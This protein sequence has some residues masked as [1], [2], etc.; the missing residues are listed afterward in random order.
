MQPMG[1]NGGKDLS[2]LMANINMNQGGAGGTPAEHEIY[3]WIS[4]LLNPES[5]EKALLEL[6]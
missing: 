2:M 5:R 1:G 4:N 3:T 6:W